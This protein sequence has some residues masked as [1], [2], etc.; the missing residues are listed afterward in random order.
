MKY[1]QILVLTGLLF[2]STTAQAAPVFLECEIKDKDSSRISA[3]T[4]DEST[5]KIAHGVKGGTTFSTEGFFTA[6]AIIY[7]NISIT[8][9]IKMTSRYE[10]NRTTLEFMQTFSGE[11]TDPA[12]AAQ[13]SGFT[14]TTK[15]VCKVVEVTDRKI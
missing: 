6:N 3:I 14:D 13:L 15:G 10:I 8:S 5:T 11:P 12:I 2:V 1:T 7:Q 9:G 4:L